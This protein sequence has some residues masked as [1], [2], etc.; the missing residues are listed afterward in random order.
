MSLDTLP[1]A[2][3]RIARLALLAFGLFAALQFSFAVVGEGIFRA[4]S[5]SMWQLAAGDALECHFG[6]DMMMLLRM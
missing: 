5:I 1:Q 3:R 6:I 4:K 2:G